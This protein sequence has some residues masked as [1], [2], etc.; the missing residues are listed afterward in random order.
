M[1]YIDC[2]SG[3]YQ[4]GSVEGNNDRPGCG[5]EV[6]ENRYSSSTIE[7]CRDQCE[8]N[9]DCN[10]FSYA[11]KGG[12]KAHSDQTVCTLY[13]NDQPSTNWGYQIFCDLDPTN[14]PTP[15]PTSNPTPAP[16]NN[17]TPSPTEQPTPG[18][19]YM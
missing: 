1:L 19:F 7:E 8:S 14:D 17:P 10:A 11:P 3:T 13:L 6:C 12:D 9:V 5:L 2:P 18:I 4:V 16:T 15:A